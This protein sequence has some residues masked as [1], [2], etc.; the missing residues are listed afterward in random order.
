MEKGPTAL[1]DVDV[2][3]GVEFD[4]H[5]E[6]STGQGFE[7]VG[8]HSQMF[9]RYYLGATSTE[10]GVTQTLANFRQGF[11]GQLVLVDYKGQKLP[12]WRFIQRPNPN[13]GRGR[14]EAESIAGE[15]NDVTPS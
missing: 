8:R 15:R 5:P 13:A 7:M 9:C 11:L 3:R 4:M 12:I 10:S 6:Q 14:P 1:M 2:L